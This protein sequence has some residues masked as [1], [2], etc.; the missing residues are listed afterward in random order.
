M[1]RKSKAT[2]KAPRQRNFIR[3]WRRH[4]HIGSLEKL[5]ERLQAEL[6]YEISVSQLSRIESGNQGYSQDIL[7]ALATVLRCSPADLIIR[8]P[9][10]QEA[11]WSIWDQVPENSR[12]QALQVLSA[13]KGKTGTN[14]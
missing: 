5:V 12:A 3:E 8:D 13:F 2:P 11:I 4:R 6:E 9:T 1:P 7:E 14:G 10:K